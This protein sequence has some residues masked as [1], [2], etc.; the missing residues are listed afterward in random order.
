[1]GVGYGPADRALVAIT[2]VFDPSASRAGVRIEHHVRPIEFRVTTDGSVPT[3]ASP[4]YDAARW[5][6]T[7]GTV[8][9]Q[10]FLRQVP[11]LQSATLSIDRHLAVGRSIAYAV[12]NS[13]KYTGTGAFS[14]TDSLRGSLDFHD[15]TWQ[16]W[17]G[18]SMEGVI[19]LGEAT[20]L[21]EVEVGALQVMRSW[22]LLPRR[23]GF[24][25]SADGLTWR[26]AGD[27]AH[28]IPAERADPLVH[29]FR[30]AMPP[31]TRARYVKVRAEN[32][33]PLPAWHPGAGGKAWVFVDEVAVR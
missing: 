14:L 24:W 17:E 11:M 27:V 7:T 16:G 22:I 12:P 32:A 30:Q 1:M 8:R 3:L 25:L 33:G 28:D 26:P 19:D 31:G 20:A 23:V 15:G 10:P 18:D 4:V 6:T 2:P 29:R 9:V 13:P 21:T 5:F